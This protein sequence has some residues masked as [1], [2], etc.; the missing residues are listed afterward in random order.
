M[1]NKRDNAAAFVRFMVE[2]SPL[3]QVNGQTAPFPKAQLLPGAA[4]WLAE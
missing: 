2:E 1:G 3:S 4:G